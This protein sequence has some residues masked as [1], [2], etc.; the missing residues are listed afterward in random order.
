MSIRLWIVIICAFILYNI[1]YENKA[2][3]NLKKYKSI[4]KC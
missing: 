1:Y 4:T 3:M 2:F